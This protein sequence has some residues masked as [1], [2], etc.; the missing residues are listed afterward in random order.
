MTLFLLL[1]FL[2]IAS[3]TFRMLWI[4]IM[5]DEIGKGLWIV[6]FLL[7]ISRFQERFNL[8]LSDQQHTKKTIL[9][10]IRDS[11]SKIVINCMFTSIW[12]EDW[13][14]KII[15]LQSKKLNFLGRNSVRDWNAFKQ[16]YEN[17][18]ELF[19]SRVSHVTYIFSHFKS[20]E[21]ANK[22]FD[23]RAMGKCEASNKIFS[24]DDF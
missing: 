1:S 3:F 11:F 6:V 10:A 15:I 23:T 19:S 17:H 2:L 4:K 9:I 7:T 8:R 22:A 14:N 18:K 21:N 5:W 13:K 16:N 20:F 24:I 12:D